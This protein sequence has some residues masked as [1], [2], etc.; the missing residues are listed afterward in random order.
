[1]DKGEEFQRAIASWGRRRVFV[2]V[3]ILMVAVALSALGIYLLR[4]RSEQGQ[5]IRYKTEELTQGDL[6]V[7]ISATGTLQPLNQVE[8]GVE[9]S[10][11]IERVEVD[12]NSVVKKGQLLAKL[13]TSRLEAQVQQSK[14]ELELAKAKEKEAEAE[15]LLAKTKLG[16]LK[17]AKEISGGRV[18]SQA[19]LDIALANVSKAE[20]L[21]FQARSLVSKAEADLKFNQTNLSKAYIRSPLDG[22]V[23]ARKV[24]PG[25]TVAASLQTPVLFT[26]AE[27]LSKMELKVD[28]DE[29]DIG[30]V[31][32]GQYAQFTVDA[33]PDKKF[34][35]KVKEIRLS[36]KVTQGV[37]TYETLLDV[38]NPELLLKPGMTATAHIIVRQLKDVLLIPNGALRFSPPSQAAQV[39]RRGILGALMPFRPPP[40]V[41]SMAEGK[42]GGVQSL[43]YKVEGDKLVPVKVTLG[44]TD[45]RKTHLKSGD[46]KPGDLVAVGIIQD[47]DGK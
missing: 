22:I 26:I 37:V 28:V 23:L 16:Q 36:P 10:G 38:E 45:G 27:D 9:I 21:V 43:A 7:R 17:Q 11:T 8:I 35:A 15:L 24:E 20:A 41:P 32:L 14:A 1:M 34:N 30:K 3:L 39:Q 2:T 31:A 46:L 40:Q 13:D 25:Q 5:K 6:T 18:P 47:K 19:E 42:K 12:Y 33:Y 44:E 4:S 29:A